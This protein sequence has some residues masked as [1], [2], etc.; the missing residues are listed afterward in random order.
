MNSL[1]FIVILIFC[2]NAYSSY[3]QK[4]I[5]AFNPCSNLDGWKRSD[6]RVKFFLEIPD[7]ENTLINAGINNES[8]DQVRPVADSIICS[9]L[10]DIVLNSP[11][12][13]S[14]DDSLDEKRTRYYYRTD[15]FYYIFWDRKPEYDNTPST[16]PKKLFIIVSADYEHVWETYN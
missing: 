13:K 16:S 5:K 15:N 7:K 11:R 1:K 4:Q 12:L 10:N 8:I 6:F 2:F 3:A 14:I 9:A